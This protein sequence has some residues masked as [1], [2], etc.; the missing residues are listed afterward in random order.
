MYSS[1]T[2]NS[3]QHSAERR[4]SRT[5][6]ISR[7]S[8]N[9]TSKLAW[10]RRRTSLRSYQV[11]SISQLLNISYRG[12][13][14][15]S[16][17]NLR[18]KIKMPDESCFSRIFRSFIMFVFIERL[19]LSIQVPL[20]LHC[21]WFY[22]FDFFHAWYGHGHCDNLSNWKV[23]S[24]CISNHDSWGLECFTATELKRF[25]VAFVPAGP[26]GLQGVPPQKFVHR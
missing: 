3:T 7:G 13:C 15:L 6:G 17:H 4:T 2:R 9:F 22:S 12:S 11:C 26:Y 25:S 19:G 5:Y 23:L 18:V 24:T 1:A 10:Q 20:K 14:I 8:F 16:W 21:I